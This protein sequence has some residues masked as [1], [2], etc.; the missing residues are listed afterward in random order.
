VHRADERR[1]ARGVEV[2]RA[3][4]DRGRDRGLPQLRERADRADQH[5][6]AADE[7]CH[8]RP[9]GD[10]RDRGLQPPEPLRERREPGGIAP[11]EQRPQTSADH[12][13]GRA[14]AGVAGGPEQHDPR[15]HGRE[16]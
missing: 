10:L 3:R 1:L 11:R 13:L 14:G 12:R 9:I 15:A 7:R 6:T 4:V 5:V 2:H 16:P 8:R